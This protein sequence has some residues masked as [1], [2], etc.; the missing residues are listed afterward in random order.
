MAVNGAASSAVPDLRVAQ[1]AYIGS[2]TTNTVYVINT[3]NQSVGAQIAVGNYPKGVAVAPDGQYA[4]VT[5]ANDNTVSV[6]DA[7]TQSVTATI[8]VGSY[9]LSVAV[10]PDS[11][12]AYVTNAHDNTVSVIAASSLAVVD[13]IA[14][15]L[16][17][18]GVCVAPDGGRV[19]VGN[20]HAQTISVIDTATNAIIDTIDI[21]YI[22]PYGVAISPTGQELY[23]GDWNGGTVALIDAH[24]NRFTKHTVVGEY[25]AYGLVVIPNATYAY[26]TDPFGSV[27]NVVHASTLDLA[28]RITLSERK[29][30][31][32]IAATPDGL[33]VYVVN[34]GGTVAVIDTKTQT[35]ANTVVI[36]FTQTLNAFGN[37]ISPNIVSQVLPVASEGVLQ[38]M[39]FRQSVVLRGGTLQIAAN[40][41]DGHT[42]SL[43]GPGGTIDTNGFDADFSGQIVGSG[44]L[45]KDGPGTLVLT[46]ANNYRGG[47]EIRGGTLVVKDNHALGSGP[48]QLHGGNLRV[49]NEEPNSHK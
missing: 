19:Y 2:R 5:N 49:L 23:A 11:Q 7:S 3:G 29:Y 18:L 33:S 40:L 14:V 44:A 32:G 24:T 47:T 45:I 21:G 16:Y 22:G 17:P 13:T 37:F 26:I 30:P 15:G 10:T 4:Y 48:V 39:G 20:T 1:D 36:D 28:K 46:G 41:H 43:L 27:V 6:I 25:D 9:P 12:Y 34:L 42:I 8:Q 38:E 31:E 35:V